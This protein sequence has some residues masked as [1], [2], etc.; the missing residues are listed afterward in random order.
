MAAYSSETQVGAPVVVGSQANTLLPWWLSGS[1]VLGALLMAT[2]AIIAL[3]HPAMLVAPG[4]EINSA[5][6]IYAGYLVSRN[7]ALAVMLVAMLGMR[8]RG[9]L[10]SLML[11]T[12]FIQLLDTGVDCMEGRWA[13]VPGVT[14]F[15]IVFFL[16]AARLSG[17]PFWKAGAWRDG[18]SGVSNR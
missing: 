16:G 4:A 6:R 1:V 12:A 5:A 9:T 14:I 11:L 18:S 10:S 15:G 3:V 2:G 13:V 17:Q 7:L 8:A